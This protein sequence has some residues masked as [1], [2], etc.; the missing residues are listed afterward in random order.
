MII[1]FPRTGIFLSTV[2]LLA[3][4]VAPLTAQAASPAASVPMTALYPAETDYARV[5]DEL[6]GL[7]RQAGTPS[8]NDKQQ[9]H[10]AML[11]QLIRTTGAEVMNAFAA[12]SPEKAAFLQAFT[13]DDEWLETYLSAGL[14]PYQTEVGLDVLFRIWQSEK[15]DVKNKPLACAC[16]S[17][18]GGG[19]T[20]QKPNILTTDPAHHNPVWRYNYFQEKAAQGVLHPNYKNLKTWELRFVVGIPQQDWEDES[21]TWAFENIN[22]PWDQYGNACW[23]GEYTDPSKFGDNVQSGEYHYPYSEMSWAQ[24]THLNGGVCGSLS[25][26]GVLACMAH[27]IPAYAVGQPGH[28]A[29]AYRLERG[30][31]L[32]GFGGPDGNMHNYIFGKSAPTSYRLMETVFGDDTA[33]AAAYRESFIAEAL[34]AAG[35]T[36]DAVAAWKRAL[37]LSPKHPFFRAALHKLLLAQGMSPDAAYDYL[38]DVLPLYDNQGMSGVEMAADLMPLIERMND[39]QKIEL[40]M[41]MHR[42][43]ATTRVQWAVNDPGFSAPQMA[44]LSSDAVREKFLG[45]IFALH[46]SEGDGTVFG[47]LLEWAVKEYVDKGQTDFFGRA[48]AAAAA[49][50]NPLAGG[51]DEERVKK[52]TAAYGKAIVAAEQAKSVPAFRTLT[53]S[54]L[55]AL[56]PVNKEKGVIAHPDAVPGTPAACSLF[57]ISTNDN[58]DTPA[59][60]ASLMTPQGGFCCTKREQKPT[61]IADLEKPATMTGCII[62][63]AS[64]N[65][66]RMKKATVYTSADGATWFPRATTDNMPEEWAVTFPVD[67]AG[68]HVKVEFDNGNNADFAHITHF[69]IYTK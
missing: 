67:T 8:A 14:V 30:K 51:A 11:L 66:E 19:E 18:W 3:A 1:M 39:A 62:R 60:H 64:F 41:M 15:G 33:I 57:R 34:A 9:L 47:L 61:L 6:T 68:K 32:G 26:L 36:D 55:T 20:W 5:A 16:A 22:L 69:V 27:G 10:A 40:F 29:Y 21:Y 59:L 13:T 52:M 49:K 23:A 28:C 65:Q 58:I 12:S 35:R 2:G 63:K 50:G 37:K 38:K 7:I 45:D 42:N 48:F 56:K 54:A 53:E 24:A 46:M 25:R 44:V 17:A 4:G 31:W 43:I